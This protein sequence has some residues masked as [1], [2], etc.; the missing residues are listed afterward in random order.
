MRNSSTTRAARDEKIAAEIIAQILDTYAVL[1][2]ANDLSPHNDDINRALSAYVRMTLQEPGA[3]VLSLVFNDAAIRKA[4]PQILTLLSRAE[5]AMEN[6]FAEHFAARGT[7]TREDLK[8]FWYLQNYD[9]LVQQDLNSLS[10]LND[11]ANFPANWTPLFLGSGPL[12][13][14]AVMLHYKMGCNV[15]CVDFDQQAVDTSRAFIRAL[16]LENAITIE[17]ADATTF[18]DYAAHKL[19]FVAALINNKTATLEKIRGDAP[20]ALVAI[21]SVENLRRLLYRALDVKEILDMGFEQKS[22]AK[23]SNITVNSTYIFKAPNP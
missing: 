1:R 22:F 23:S 10:A 12:P 9:E 16:G 17:Q 20:G 14:S 8:D 13:L 15:R 2:K 11:G 21:R 5:S 18:P 4:H 6:Y 19:I 3:R 7:I